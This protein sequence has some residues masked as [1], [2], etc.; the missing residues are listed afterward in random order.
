MTVTATQSAES[1]QSAQS[2]PATG[3]ART[4]QTGAST[5][6]IVT[7]PNGV[8]MNYQAAQDAWRA[9]GLH[10]SPAV[11]ATG[12]NRLPI[13]DSNWVVLSQDPPAG[14]RVAAG[15]FIVATVKKYSDN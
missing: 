9:A 6:A 5:T 8:G 1:A 10:V 12:A 15:S 3:P 14:S 2:T 4:A 11:D 13:V 7:V